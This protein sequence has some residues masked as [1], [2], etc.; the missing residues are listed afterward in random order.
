[1][2]NAE[3]STTVGLHVALLRGINVGGRNKLPMKELAAHFRDAGC[4]D[5]QTYIQSGNVIYRAAETLAAELPARIRAALQTHHGL[6]VPVVTRTAAELR[7]VVRHHLFL[8]RGVQTKQIH[9]GFLEKTPAPDRAATL[10]PHRSPPDTFVLHGRELYLHCPN[11]M[12][13]TKL[14]NA[15]FDA[16]LDTVSTMRNHKTLLA[17]LERVADD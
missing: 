9:V 12:A 17:L 5:V 8:G 14:T 1:M 11:G 10:D 2:A 6:S 4:R 7:A 16:R 3:G 13:R 15:Y